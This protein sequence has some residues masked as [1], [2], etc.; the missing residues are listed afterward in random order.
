MP[1]V[2]RLSLAAL[3]V[4]GCLGGKSL[5]AKVDAPSFNLAAPDLTAPAGG[6]FFGNPGVWGRVNPSF[7]GYPT[8]S[9]ASDLVVLSRAAPHPQTILLDG[10]FNPL[11][12]ASQ[13]GASSAAGGRFNLTFFGS[14]G[15]DFMFD[16][17]FMGDFDQQ[18]TVGTGGGVNLIF[19]QGLAVDPVDT[20]SYRSKLDTGEFNLRRRVSPQ[21]GLLAGIRE[22][23][24]SE[25]MDFSDSG[26]SVNAAYTSQAGNQLFGFQ[27]G[28]EAVLPARGY[29]RF[30]AMGK[31]GIYNDHFR[32]GAQALSGG[33]PIHVQV[34]DDMVS[35]VGDFNVGF[36]VQTVPRMT[37]RFGYQLLWINNAALGVDQL[38]QFS[39]FTND[40][41]VRKSNPVY[42]GGFVGLVFVF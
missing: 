2:Q 39:I 17:L 35:Y 28:A 13:L 30:F 32:I 3:V 11:L 14:S 24:I 38:N 29:G 12:N 31:Y 9:F 16:G 20:V 33:S 27:L 41:T 4:I 22:L 18:R 8:V 6:W 7:W 37:L 15:W 10:A 5:L 23:Q 34:A 26:S 40:G 42:N 25:N 21:L 1:P 19:Y 36:E